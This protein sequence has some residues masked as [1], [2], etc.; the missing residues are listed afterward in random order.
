MGSRAVIV[1][2]KNEEAATKR[3]GIENEGIG[4]CYTRTG[5]NF[6][7][8]P[9]TEK[10]FLDRVNQCLTK[11]NILGQIQHGLGL[12]GCRTHALVSKSTSIA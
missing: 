10:G 1:I 6:F 2:C 3:F 5:R 9:K 4:I 12:F 7:N 11:H 8:D